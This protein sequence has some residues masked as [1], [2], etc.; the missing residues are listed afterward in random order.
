MLCSYENPTPLGSLRVPRHSATEGSYGGGVSR[1][2]GTPVATVLVHIL[3]GLFNCY[4][5]TSLIRN[6]TPPRTFVGP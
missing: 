6:L 3:P 4:R 5:G 1:E 2:R